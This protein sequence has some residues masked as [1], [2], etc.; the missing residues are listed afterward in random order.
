MNLANP[1]DEFVETKVEPELRPL[2]TALRDVLKENAPKAQEVISYGMLTY[3]L[4]RPLAWILPS[5]TGIT[6]GFREGMHFEDKHNLLR[7]T[8]KHAKHIRMKR[9]DE[10]DKPALR[11]YIKQAVKLDQA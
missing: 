4:K 7:G 1:C 6:L 10:V 5:K 8:A 3:G 2:V 9:L 11:Y